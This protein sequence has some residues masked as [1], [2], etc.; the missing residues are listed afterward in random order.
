MLR[1]EGRH[2]VRLGVVYVLPFPW[3]MVL[4]KI[5]RGL[6]WPYNMDTG[7]I[8]AMRGIVSGYKMSWNAISMKT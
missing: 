7:G 3:H 5:Y 2:W 6:R 4:Y 1:G 8:D